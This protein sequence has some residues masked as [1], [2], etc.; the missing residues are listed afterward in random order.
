M[1]G[2]WKYA[3]LQQLKLRGES[4]QSNA[5]YETLQMLNKQ[6][7]AAQARI[8][9]LAHDKISN[10]LDTVL[11]ENQD[12]KDSIKEKDRIIKEKELVN[13]ELIVAYGSAKKDRESTRE[14]YR[15]LEVKFTQLQEE[16]TL[17]KRNMETITDKI[18]ELQLENNMLLANAK[19]NK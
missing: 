16:I 18:F 14:D 2:D 8:E 19:T 13:N 7:E 3:V 4:I 10:T 11:T 17:G 12:L 6:L 9:I 1:D 15:K 5:Y